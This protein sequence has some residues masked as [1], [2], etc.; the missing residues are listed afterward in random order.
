M[1]DEQRAATLGDAE[2]LYQ[3]I[4]DATGSDPKKAVHALSAA[5]GLAAVAECRVP[6]RPC[7]R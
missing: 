4:L 2:K 1:T 6:G 5:Y 3:K 7:T